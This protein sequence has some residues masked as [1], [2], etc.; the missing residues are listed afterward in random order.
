[1]GNHAPDC[2]DLALHDLPLLATFAPGCFLQGVDNA[3][4]MAVVNAEAVGG[5]QLVVAKGRRTRTA[6]VILV[7]AGLQVV[8]AVAVGLEGVDPDD[9]LPVQPRSLRGS[10]IGA[11]EIQIAVWLLR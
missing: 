2:L 9:H 6:L 1:M 8:S 3:V 5:E 7:Q 10:N 4:A 11:L